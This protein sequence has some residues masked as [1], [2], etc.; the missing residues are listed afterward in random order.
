MT[1]IPAAV[2]A[3]RGRHAMELLAAARPASLD[4]PAGQAAPAASIIATFAAA[5][6]Q[7]PGSPGQHGAGPGGPAARGPLPRLGD[8]PARGGRLTR[9]SAWAGAGVAITAGAAVLAGILVAPG[10]GTHQ[11]RAAAPAPSARAILLAAAAKAAAA[12]SAGQYW[13]VETVS[14]SVSAAGPDAHPFAVEQRWSPSVSW[15][16]RSPSQR[17]WTLPAAGYTTVP[18]TAGARAAWLADGSPALPAASSPQQAWWQT[19]GGVGYFGNSSPTL[20]QF[21]A[22]PSSPAG[23]AA[24]VRNAALRQQETGERAIRAFGSLPGLSQFMFGIY[25]QLLKWDPITPQVRAAV[26]RDI[27]TLPGVRSVG[28]ITDPLGRSGYGIAMTAPEPAAGSGEEEVLVISPGSGSLL[29]DEYLAVGPGPATGTHAVGAVPGLTACPAGAA[30][31]PSPNA[32]QGGVSR[33]QPGGLVPV[34]EVGGGIART[35]LPG[36]RL[37]LPAGTVVSYDAILSAGWT[38]ASPQLPPPSE[39]FSTADDGQG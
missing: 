19:G 17:S 1:R 13:R 6:V 16:A 25:V 34:R 35:S 24:A 37:A 29:A 2:P 20:A 27:A 8:R 36:P 38:N 4:P 9:R 7:A 23:L 22:L 15:D 30:P 11:A 12:S 31:G 18:A 39:Q 28:K 21:Q 3:R 26:F 32:C 5:E 14:A 33:P 10:T